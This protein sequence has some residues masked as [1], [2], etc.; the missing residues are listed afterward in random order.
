MAYNNPNMIDLSDQN[1]PTK[2]TERFSELYDNQWTNAFLILEKKHLL[3]ETDIISVLLDVLYVSF[4][5]C[6]RARSLRESA[7]KVIAEYIGAVGDDQDVRVLEVMRTLKD[8]RKKSV[9]EI[10]QTFKKSVAERLSTKMIYKDKL[11]DIKP[12]MDE[13]VEICTA[14]NI[15]EPPLELR[16]VRVSSDIEFEISAFKPYT[17]SG[18]KIEYIVWP[19]LHLYIDGPILCKGVAQGMP[20]SSNA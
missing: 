16:G 12:Y 13:C 15:Q 17:V 10:S 8:V 6:K 11:P 3:S 19:A 2:I 18:K 1:N 14:M 5:E 7:F 9:G 4:T 20:C